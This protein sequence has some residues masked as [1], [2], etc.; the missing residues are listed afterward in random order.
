M[1]APLRF[2]FGIAPT[3]TFKSS[4]QHLT[5]G[6]WVLLKRHLARALHHH[7]MAARQVLGALSSNIPATMERGRGKQTGEAMTGVA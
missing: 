3:A 4:G 7:T 6:T 2:W 1:T 5:K